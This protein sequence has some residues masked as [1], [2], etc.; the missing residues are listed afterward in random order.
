MFSPQQMTAPVSGS[1]FRV[2]VQ[3]LQTW[4]FPLNDLL[5]SCHQEYI[6]EK[7]L[8]GWCDDKITKVSNPLFWGLK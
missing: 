8:S 2:S 7:E 4:F 1:V 3:M 5:S 6:Q